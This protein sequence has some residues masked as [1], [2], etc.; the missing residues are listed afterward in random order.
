[1]KGLP[2]YHHKEDRKFIKE[3]V[4]KLPSHWRD[5]VLEVY[6]DK[7]REIFYNEPNEVMRTNLARK[8]A[9]KWL[10]GYTKKYL[11]RY[12]QK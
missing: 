5:Q 9:N 7:Y 1:M 2:K 3:Q 8:T 6:S 12:L 4:A 10:L 11:D